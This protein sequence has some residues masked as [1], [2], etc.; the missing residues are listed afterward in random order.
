MAFVKNLLALVSDVVL[1]CGFLVWSFPQRPV[2]SRHIRHC[3]RVP[4]SCSSF[5]QTQINPKW[6]SGGVPDGWGRGH[7]VGRKS[8]PQT[9]TGVERRACMSSVMTSISL[10][11]SLSLSL[12]G[13]TV[14]LLWRANN[15]REKQL[16]ESSKGAKKNMWHRVRDR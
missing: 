15:P 7:E 8:V 14:C 16:D 2:W 12:W 1:C 6:W 3:H 9:I 4:F 13:Q 5:S 11:F 10:S